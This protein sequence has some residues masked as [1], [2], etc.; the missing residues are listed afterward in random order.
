MTSTPKGSNPS[1][2][3]EKLPPKIAGKQRRGESLQNIGRMVIEIEAAAVQALAGRIDDEFARACRHM[4]DCEGRVIVL[5][6]GKSG[7]VGSKIAATLASTGTP[8]FFVHPA[9]ARHG[10]LGMIKNKDVVLAISNSGRTEEILALLPAI[11]ALKVVLIAMTGNPDSPLAKAARVH[12]NVGVEREACPLESAPTASTTAALAMGD[13]LAI[14][15]LQAKEQSHEDFA[16][17]HPGGALGRRLQGVAALMHTG[18]EI[19][20]VTPDTLIRDALIEMSRKGLGMTA[21][22]DANDRLLGVFTDGDLRRAFDRDVDL[23]SA[24]VR[25]VM[26]SEAR[27]VPPD[28]LA[29]EAV[30]LMETQRINALVVV[31]ES[32]KL[33]GALNMHDLLRAGVA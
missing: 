9:E 3:W 5:G 22:T 7:H 2:E 31:D 1:A 28:M 14:A 21:I 4:R 11:K 27:S 30:R 16:R 8:A 26:T 32:G 6:V 20:K 23:R 33:V 12:I 10:D 25:E 15:I 13:A 18:T 17:S 19:P 29:V 24:K